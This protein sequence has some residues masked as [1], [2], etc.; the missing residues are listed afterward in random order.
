MWIQ[1]TNLYSASEQIGTEQNNVY[2][3]IQNVTD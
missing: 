3:L 2:C 1:V